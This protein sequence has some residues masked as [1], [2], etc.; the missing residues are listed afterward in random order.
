MKGIPVKFLLLSFFLLMFSSAVHA[1]NFLF[2]YIQTENQKPF[3]IKM[4]GQSIPSSSSGHIIIP[5]L[6]QGSYKIAIGFTQSDQ[7][8]F[9]VIIN[10]NETDV[11]YILK[12][13][14]DKTWYM[15]DLLNQKPLKTERQLPVVKN[16]IAFVNGDEF[17]KILSEV[18]NDSSIRKIKS[19]EN[20]P[21]KPST[22]AM[23]DVVITIKD[24][25]AIPKTVKTSTNKSCKK[26]ATK[27]VFL[28]LQK[29]MQAQKTE[30]DKR[31]V[32]SKSFISTCFTTDQIKQLGLLFISEEG[33]YK[34]YVAA[35]PH[36][37]DKE[38]F[39]ALENQFTDNYY[40]SRFKA[41][42]NH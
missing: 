16:E 8:G 42:F 6:T 15:V 33:K 34:F 21:V 24:T 32:A 36:V 27:T 26:I 14:I 19:R 29:Q 40:L 7:P 1:Q 4:G 3:Y 30:P 35:F 41:M 22:E 39:E 13:D 25:S 23:P 20:N 11:G 12:P 37:Y 2:I 17:A 5:R 18:V 9:T 10:L 38:N 28:K 31:V